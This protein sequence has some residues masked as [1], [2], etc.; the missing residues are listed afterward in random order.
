MHIKHNWVYLRKES[1][2]E[3]T[4]IQKTEISEQCDDCKKLRLRRISGWWHE[5]EIRSWYYPKN[6][7]HEYMGKP[8]TYCGRGICCKG[9]GHEGKCDY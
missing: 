7:K 9:D 3:W 4:G 8:G 1:L 2:F 5:D 6:P